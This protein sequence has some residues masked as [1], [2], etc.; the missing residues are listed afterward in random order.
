M[1]NYQYI[2][3]TGVIVADTSSI[4]SDVQQEFRDAFNNQDLIVTAD[5]P[6][7]V[8]IVAE[9]LA[10][11]NVIKN[12]VAIANQINPNIAGGSFLDAIMA[13]TGMARVGQTQS[14]LIGVN[15]AGVPNTVIPEGSQAQTATQDVFSTASTVTLSAAGT[16]TVD[17]VSVEFK[18]ITCAALALNQIVTG[19]LGWETVSNPAAA[20]IGSTTQSDQQARALRANTLAFQGVALMEA[21]TSSLYAVSGVKSLQSL[22]NRD[23]TT[24]VMSGVTLLPHSF[25]F[26]VDGGTNKDVA[27]CLLENKSSGCNWNGSQNVTVI[28]PSSGQSYAVRFDRPT[29]KGI[30]IKATVKKG[31]QAD[32]TSAILDYANGLIAG[33]NGFTVGQTVSPF[34]IAG[35]INQKFP[36]IYVQKVELSLTSPVSYAVAEIPINVNEIAYTQESYITVVVA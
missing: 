30:L 10:R 8:L 29:V 25:Y 3:D 7:G 33:E 1:A 12:N 31:S 36:A 17:F 35:A 9:T 21:I 2:T 20:V 22:E 27:S 4:L 26:C 23:A 16:A 28:E 11:E 6:Q 32:V 19:I 13:F 18:P 24:V 34:E 14:R 15:V 5:T